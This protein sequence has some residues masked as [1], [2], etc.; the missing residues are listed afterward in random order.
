LTNDGEVRAERAL[1]CRKSAG[2]HRA[3]QE[4]L[5]PEDDSWAARG[6]LI[7]VLLGTLLWA[8][9]GVAAYFILAP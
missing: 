6:V 5:A 9:I 3:P 8:G 2:P 7:A 1:A 4:V